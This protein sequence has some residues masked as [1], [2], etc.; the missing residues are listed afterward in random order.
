MQFEK[1]SWSLIA[2]ST[3]ASSF[4]SESYCWHLQNAFP[5]GLPRNK[6][7]VPG[8][9]FCYNTN[10]LR[11]FEQMPRV[12][13]V[14]Y[15]CLVQMFN[16]LFQRTIRKAVLIFPTHHSYLL[17]FVLLTQVVQC[18]TAQVKR[19]RGLFELLFRIFILYWHSWL[20]SFDRV[21]KMSTLDRT[22]S[23]VLWSVLS[24]NTESQSRFGRDKTEFAIPALNASPVKE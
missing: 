20:N 18:R 11:A 1:N 9:T 8:Y 12:G 21:V 24:L 5:V 16:I 3:E 14:L 7:S 23:Q 4:L 10:G 19:R 13:T 22:A 6:W 2:E 17:P 15:L